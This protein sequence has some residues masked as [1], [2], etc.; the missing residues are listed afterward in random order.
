MPQTTNELIYE[1]LCAVTKLP[2]GTSAETVMETWQQQLDARAVAVGLPAS[3][4]V[5]D[6]VAAERK[7]KDAARMAAAVQASAAADAALFG[8]GRHAAPVAAPTTPLL[9]AEEASE[10]LLFGAQSRHTRKR[11]EATEQHHGRPLRDCVKDGL[12]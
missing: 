10:V 11:L 1:K 2:V 12:L 8:L 3:S 4:P 6:I 9:A 7:A 5:P